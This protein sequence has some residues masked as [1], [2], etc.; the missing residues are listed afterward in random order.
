MLERASQII[1][2]RATQ[3]LGAHAEIKGLT[4]GH[5]GSSPN[6]VLLPWDIIGNTTTPKRKLKLVCRY[7]SWCRTEC[8]FQPKPQLRWMSP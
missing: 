3:R 5:R 7:P 1:D 6:R 2:N 4:A 8:F